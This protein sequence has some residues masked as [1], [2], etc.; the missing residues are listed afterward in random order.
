MLGVVAIHVDEAG[1]A[2]FSPPAMEKGH[3]F[4]ISPA[5]G[6]RAAVLD[7]GARKDHQGVKIECLSLN[8]NHNAHIK[9]RL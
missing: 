8:S 5:Q 7:A 6:R 9:M 4:I 2:D 3:P 1:T